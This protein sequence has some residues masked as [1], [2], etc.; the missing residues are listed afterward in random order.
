LKVNSSG[1]IYLALVPIDLDNPAQT[2]LELYKK[3]IG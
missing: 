1:L 2:E 3:V